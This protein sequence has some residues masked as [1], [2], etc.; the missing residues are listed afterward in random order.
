MSRRLFPQCSPRWRSVVWARSS[1]TIACV[2]QSSLASVTGVSHSPYITRA[3]RHILCPRIS[4]L[5]SCLLSR[6][7]ALR[8]RASHLWHASRSGP[9]RVTHWSSLQCPVLPA[10]RHTTC[11]IW[12]HATRRLWY[13]RRPTTIGVMW[14]SML[15]VLSTLR[16]T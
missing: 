9:T 10:H 8:S 16:D 14:T 4:C 15:V 5:W 6:T 7:S 3:I 11:V 12:T 2:T 1:S 13:R